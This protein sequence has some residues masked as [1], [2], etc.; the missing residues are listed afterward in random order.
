MKQLVFLF[1][2]STFFFKAQSQ[3]TKGIWLVGGSGSFYSY[4]EDYQTPSVDVTAKY[5]TIDVSAS[6][7]Y[8][9]IDKLSGGLRPY[10]SSFK[11]ES[12][13][14]GIINYHRLAVGPFARYYF[15]NTEKPFNLLADVSYQFGTNRDNAGLSYKG[16]F[17]M[18]S[19]MAGPEVFFNT[20]AGLE[21]LMGYAQKITSLDNSPQA[22]KSNKK[23]LQVSLGFQ[24]HL[25]RL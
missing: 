12:S 14:G 16:K 2:F 22:S 21:I 3:L 17:N 1:A 20:S 25:E 24:L 10:F 15:L 5:T 7:G 8:F 18:F 4:H 6:I 9:S 19:I 23:G 11:G 13:G